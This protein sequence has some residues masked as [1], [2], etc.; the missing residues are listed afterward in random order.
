MGEPEAAELDM[1]V[2]AGRQ[3]ADLPAPRGEDLVAPAEA[4]RPA[5]MVEHD[6][7]LGKGARQVDEFA[8]LGVVNPGVE[9]EAE[10][11]EP[12]EPLARPGVHQQACGPNDRGPP[13]RLVGVRGGDEADAAEAAAAGRDHGLEDLLHWCAQR[14][15]NIADAARA[16]A[17]L[18]YA[19]G[20]RD[21][22]ELAAYLFDRLHNFR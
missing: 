8:E 16:G 9:A 3:L 2:W 21:G 13:G 18:P 17:G 20:R 1:D 14:Q 11:G 22:P 6:L 7:C 10:R 19:F 4:D 5:D 12:R 15:I